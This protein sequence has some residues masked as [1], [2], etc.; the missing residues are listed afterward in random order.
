MELDP[1]DYDIVKLLTKLK[2]TNGAYPLE[3]LTLR[4]QTY[5]Q[6]VAEI[7]LGFGV[8]SGLK[9]TIK[10][11]GK[12]GSFS[13]AAGG[14]VEAALVMA[15]V[16]EA[17][18]AAYIYKDEITALIQSNTSQPRVVEVTSAPETEFSPILPE[19]VITEPPEATTTTPL[20]EETP[21]GTPVPG[22]AATDNNPSSQGIQSNST[23]D[24]NG[25]NG[26]QYGLTP[27]SD[28][29]KKPVNN[30]NN[31]NKDKAKDKGKDK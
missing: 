17:G 4:R 25:N 26:N 31:N 6:R 3:L 9:T 1:K 10:S 19:L 16:A 12:G 20:A 28:R 30:D 8:A 15:I 7:G 29:T 24:P 2:N 11:G 14:W 22:A 5:V 18:A 13:T 23:P 21:S 27:K